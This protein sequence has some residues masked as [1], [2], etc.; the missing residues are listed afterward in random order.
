[1]EKAIR[2]LSTMQEN[3]NLSSFTPIGTYAKYVQMGDKDNVENI[4]LQQ[5]L[6]YLQNNVLIWEED[7]S[8]Q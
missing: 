6:D 3:G 4:N 7:F 1:M 5:Y 8:N 2:E